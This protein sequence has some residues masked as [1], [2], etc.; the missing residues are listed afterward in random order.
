M[1]STER[2]VAIVPARGG[3]KR[4]PRKNIKDFLGKPM[5]AYALDALRA[6]RLFD[7]IV[8]ST[9]DDEIAE[10]STRHGADVPFRR[11]AE[12]SDDRASTD[13]VLLH[14]VSECR[15]L[16]GPIRLGCCVYPTSPFL[17]GEDLAAGRELLLTHRATSAFPVVR[18][19]F[20]IEQ[21]FVL[22]GARARAKWPDKM[23]VGSQDLPPHYHDAGMFY[24]FDVEKYLRVGD[25][26]CDDNVVFVVAADRCQDINTPEDWARAELKYR[27]VHGLPE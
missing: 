27:I 26:F 10:V 13:A 21:A 25:L 2:T 20:P 23:A 4:I 17:A 11:P 3:S 1:N 9:D 22:E 24:W 6:S 15:R 19:D 8:V 5:I 18:Y 16:L 12:L 14:A 7:N